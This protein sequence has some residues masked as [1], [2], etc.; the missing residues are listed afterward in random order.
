MRRAALVV[1]I[2]VAIVVASV[3]S[4][5]AALQ[6]TGYDKSTPA[7]SAS[8]LATNVAPVV[9][10]T[11]TSQLAVSGTLGYSD[12]YVVLNETQGHYTALPTPGQLINEGD[13]IYQVDGAP[14]ILLYGST[15]A[16]RTLS[17]YL[18]GADVVQL[19]AALVALGYVSRSNLDPSSSYFNWWTLYG[20]QRLQQHLGLSQ[21]GSLALGTVVFLP[22]GIRVTSITPVLGSPA[23]AGAPVAAATSTGRRVVVNLDAF[24][25]SDVKVGDQVTIS[26]P[27]GRTT[28]GTVASVGSVATTPSGPGGGTPTVEVDIK[29]TDQAATGTLDAAPVSVLIT[30]ATAPNVLA[31]PVTAL[32]ATANGGYELEVLTSTGRHEM[33]PVTVGLFDDSDGLVQVSGNGLEAGQQVVVAGT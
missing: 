3:A 19:N 8:R 15:P 28:P 23:G 26:L 14:V 16:Y 4:T 10:R 30:I 25:Q 22:T 31:V 17:E 2:V 27:N 13:S 29:P 6:L 24:Q 20:T 9:Q 12:N 21:T 18:R 1:A 33:V 32:L 11:L 5:L 7:A